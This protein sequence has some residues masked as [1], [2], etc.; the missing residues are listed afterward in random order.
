MRRAWAPRISASGLTLSGTIHTNAGIYNGDAWNFIGG[1]NYND[2]SGT[3]NDNIAKTNQTITWSD[4]VSIVYGT[5]LAGTQLNA[6]VA[7]VA[8]GS[9]PGALTYTPASGTVLNVGSSQ[10]LH[11][12]AAATTNYNVVSTDANA[13]I[14]MYKR[15]R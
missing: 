2:A 12:V 13:I 10:T 4:P 9:A 14:D 5:A 11:V 15:R 7:G 1:T 8:G 6:A 3:V